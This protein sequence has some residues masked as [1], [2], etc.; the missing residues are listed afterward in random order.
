MG[1]QAIAASDSKPV[2]PLTT[3][4]WAVQQSASFQ[5]GRASIVSAQHF[6][7]PRSR[8]VVSARAISRAAAHAS[9]VGACTLWLFLGTAGDGRC[10]ERSNAFSASTETGSTLSEPSPIRYRSL[11]VAQAAETTPVERMIPAGSG[12]KIDNLAE[13]KQVLEREQERDRAEALART[14]TSSLRAELNAVQSNAE[15]AAIK[16]RQVLDQERN[17]AE[18][19]ARELA[20][21]R[22]QLDAA[23][24]AGKQSAEAI[25][26]GIKQTQALE[27]ERDKANELAR[28]LTFLRT[29][30]DAAHMAVSKAVQAA[31][32]EV[33][34]ARALEQERARADALT[35]DLAS[36]RAELDKARTAALE[37]AKATAAQIE[38]KRGLEPK[39]K[40][41]QDR[42]DAFARELT[43]L[44]TELD[45]A[46]AATQEA[47]RTVEAVKAEQ[48]RT[49]ERERGRA[50]ALARELTSAQKQ[51]EERSTRL[52]ATQA[53][54]LQVTEKSSTV[55]AEQ[56]KAVAGARER[57]DTLA[58]ELASVRSQLEAATNRQFAVL[59]A[60]PALIA[61][62]PAAESLVERVA[63]FHLKM[64]E[65]KRRSPD[66]PS[67]QAAASNP[68]PSSP[69]E[70]T[71]TARDAAKPDP[72]VSMV[73]EESA[74]AIGASRAPVDEER[75]LAR[76]N[77]LLRQAD[78][79]G[80][81]PM[82]EYAVNRGSARAAFMLAE[83]YD[84]RVLRSWRARGISGDPAKARELYEKAQ[85]GGIDDAKERIKTL[86]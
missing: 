18:A 48:K 69:P 10:A 32:T 19:L 3:T 41:Q 14:L 67:V 4:S 51:V 71:S 15:A 36:L 17:R 57:A 40:Q 75:L 76:A 37:T 30:L 22:P 56:K 29:E 74:S 39:L 84:A 65:G 34:Q 80:A 49:S 59:A 60:S 23:R 44:R 63:Q 47:T 82:L 7:L 83:T 20:T 50:E 24:V 85:A 81:R 16:Q 86:K 78:I 27:Q 9:A 55:A 21:L 54:V 28:E 43:S 38:Q 45:A 12:E 73:P 53:E 11:V 5:K 66:R 68:E 33:Q 62:E 6:L 13:R 52:A 2:I 25:E 79:S 61:R 72:Q 35:R 46:R 58:R 42:A 26:V 1:S 31:E 64:A 77:T 8:T 70:A